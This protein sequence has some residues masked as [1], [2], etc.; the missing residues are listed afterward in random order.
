[1]LHLPLLSVYYAYWAPYSYEQHQSLV[2]EMQCC[3]DVSLEMLVSWR[4]TWR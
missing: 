1:M 4:L 2:A 3:E